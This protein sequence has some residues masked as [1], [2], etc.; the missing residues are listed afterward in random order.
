MMNSIR[1]KIYESYFYSIILGIYEW[2][3]A[4]V[5]FRPTQY[6]GHKKKEEAVYNSWHVRIW[7]R[8]G[9][10]V[11]KIAKPFREAFY[12][13]FFMNIVNQI[14][15]FSRESVIWKV[16]KEFN[17]VYVL[18]LYIYIDKF[19]RTYI[20]GFASVWDE[21]L[22]LVFIG[23][24]IIRRIL[25]NKRYSFS[26]IDLPLLSFIG[27]Y[28]GIMF[29]YSP[30]LNVGIEGLRA[31]VQYMFWFFLVLQL[32]D[33]QV[34]IQRTIWLLTVSTGLL[35]LHGTYQYLTGAEM[36]GNWVDSS[37]T[38]TTRAYSIVGG[39][40]ALA[41]VLVLGIPIAI[42]LF[43]AEK[44]IIKKIILLFSALFMGTGLIFTFSRG[45]WIA[46][47]LAVI[48][49]FIFVGKRL[50]VPIITLLLAVV[51]L[52]DNVWNRISMLF[53]K[54]YV[55]KA[56]EGGR[57]YRWTT[58]ITEWSESKVFGLGIGRYGG[59]VATNH[60][61]APF[62]MD[63]YYLKTL[64]ESGLVGLISFIVLQVYTMV[65]C[66]FYIRGMNNKYN[67]VVSLSI[68]AGMMGVL[69]HNGVEN[70]FESPFMVTF[71][72]MCAALIVATF[73]VEQRGTYEED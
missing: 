37:E 45:A 73:K 26:D 51:L 22:I 24:I 9:S 52:V 30:E 72:W 27:I 6:S 33:R 10:E 23:W 4:S 69:M 59:A 62:Y 41:S 49:L 16:V 56:S 43:I 13:S 32:L 36:L 28:L 46:T 8:I 7:A 47:F 63:N 65:Q 38:I 50:L 48:L 1:K 44:D 40:N 70:I 68:F 58:G 42:G 55:S 61:L 29:V 11:E 35:G 57:I 54:E 20:V 39:P 14:A 60:G 18:V 71:F 15:T 66:F 53:T 67:R 12:S 19:M 2:A 21:I 5:F 34:I 31:V 3:V 17:V 25:F 64:T